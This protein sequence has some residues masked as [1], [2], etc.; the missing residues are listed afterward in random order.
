MEIIV[1][2]IPPLPSDPPE[3]RGSTSGPVEARI[4]HSRPPRSGIAGPLGM[5]RR[6]KEVHDPRRG[7]ILTILVADGQQLPSDLERAD[8]KVIMRFRKM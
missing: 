4:L 7:R 2:S 1:G 6:G 5:E 8:Y 3:K